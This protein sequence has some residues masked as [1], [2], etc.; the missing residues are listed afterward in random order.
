VFGR[1]LFFILLAFQ[2]ALANTDLAQIKGEDL[3][4]TK[5]ISIAAEGKK[6]LVVIFLSSKC[7]CSDSHNQEMNSLSKDYPDFR[8]VAVHSNVDEDLTKS[9]EYFKKADL[10]FPVIQDGKAEIADRFKALKTPHAFVVLPTGD[11]AYQG[12]ASSS[13]KFETAE[14]KYLREAL[15]D[16][17]NGRKVKTP[18]GRTLGCVISRGEKNVW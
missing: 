2:S 9:R 18:E 13:K 8:F 17:Q 3:F 12:G 14:R 1:I 16:L 5:E 10:K 15:D 6:G 4:T 7:P 11:V